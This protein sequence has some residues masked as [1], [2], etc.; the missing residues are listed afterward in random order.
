MAMVPP[1]FR[2]QIAGGVD[3]AFA[4]GNGL[5]RPLAEQLYMD[6]QCISRENFFAVGRPR[7]HLFRYGGRRRNGENAGHFGKGVRI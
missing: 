2:R 5:F 4:G 6:F 3:G 1:C 7:I